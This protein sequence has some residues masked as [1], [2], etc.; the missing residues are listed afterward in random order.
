M[1]P[2]IRPRRL[3]CATL[4]ANALRLRVEQRN[5]CAR[6]NAQW[7]GISLALRSGYRTADRALAELVQE[8]K[9]RLKLHHAAG[10]WLEPCC[11]VVQHRL[12]R[13][14]SGVPFSID[15]INGRRFRSPRTPA[16]GVISWPAAPRRDA[17]ASRLVQ[18]REQ[19][20]SPWD[21]AR[22]S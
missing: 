2:R 22:G 1:P 9:S 16:R 19:E 3:D 12:K 20:R 17:R 13:F 10:L 18:Q 5:L 11:K 14:L 4:A 21:L 8:Q 6:A 7:G 15:Q